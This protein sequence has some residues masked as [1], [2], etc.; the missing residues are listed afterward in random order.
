MCNV[1]VLY[2]AYI[3]DVALDDAGCAGA[4]VQLPVPDAAA[5]GGDQGHAHR[6]TAGACGSAQAAQEAPAGHLWPAA[7]IA[8]FSAFSVALTSDRPFACHSCVPLALLRP[9][10][11][12]GVSPE[13]VV[14]SLDHAEQG[15]R[16]LFAVGLCL[17][18]FSWD[19]CCILHCFVYPVA[20]SHWML[21]LSISCQSRGSLD[22]FVLVAIYA[23]GKQMVLHPSEH[24]APLEGMSTGPCRLV[25]SSNPSL[26]M[27]S[28]S[29][30]CS[31]WN[32]Q[33]KQSRSSK[34][35]FWRIAE[36]HA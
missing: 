24:S 20:A 6:H 36:Q 15:C 3:L 5:G 11:S 28:L 4:V 18:G 2:G 1:C 33:Y 26:S 30:H 23:E 12:R 22:S 35:A 32:R 25:C 27:R 16:C 31:F 10:V 19:L 14:L 9:H 7:S 13:D 34:L 8:C 17:T 29:V 21:Y